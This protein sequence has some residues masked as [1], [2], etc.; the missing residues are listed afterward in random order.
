MRNI[1]ASLDVGSRFIKLVVGET[2]KNNQVKILSSSCV[3]SAGV[4]K[5]AVVD[6][7]VLIEKL[8][9]VFSKCESMLGISIKQVLLIVPNDEAEFFL[10][11]GKTTIT[12][13]EHLIK[14]SDLI[15]ALQGSTYNKIDEQRE[16]VSLMPTAYRIDD[17]RNVDD[18]IGL[19]A[20]ELLVKTLVTTI[21]RENALP[22]VKCLDSIG[23][24]VI[25]FTLG[26]IG[27]YYECRNSH[28]DSSVGAMINI[29]YQKTEVSIFNKGLLTNTTKFDMGSKNMI[30]DLCYM[31]KITKKDAS[32]V[33][34][35]LCSAHTRGVLAS[36]KKSY[37]SISGE[38]VVI[39]AYEATE[40]SS[41]R[42]EEILKLAKKEIN[43]LTKKEIHYIM[44]T[45]GVSEMQ[46][47]TLTL[48]EVFGH[49]AKVASV[50]ELG[51]RSNIYSPSV[52]FIKFFHEKLQM[53]KQ[54]FSIFSDEEIESI[55]RISSKSNEEDNSI[56]GRLFGYFFDN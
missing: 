52:G 9:E 41:S 47:F 29:G 30:A 23:V 14:T 17:E 42:L 40:I 8:K 45:G 33:L 11:E 13:D 36:D 20:N 54:E 49:N 2:L 4:K 50:R 6:S 7:S 24:E 16:I 43:L 10:S 22:L 26:S 31:Y 18:P 38:E 37:T 56:L 51:V 5:G 55:C 48:E 44:I 27:D 34:E 21:P 19:E 15:H 39:N 3:S 12:N 53:R 32:D 35:N 28:M 1:M 25:D 46:N